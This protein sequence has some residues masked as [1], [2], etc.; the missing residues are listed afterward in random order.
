MC[1]YSQ[2]IEERGIEKEIDKE[3]LI[4]CTLLETKSIQ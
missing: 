3:I 4:Y 1:S 2:V